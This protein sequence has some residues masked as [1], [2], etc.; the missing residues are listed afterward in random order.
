MQSIELLVREQRGV[1]RKDY[2][3][4]QGVPVHPM[5]PE[6]VARLG[7]FDETG[8]RIPANVQVEGTD[9]DGMVRWVL[10]SFAVDVPAGDERRFFLKEAEGPAPTADRLESSTSS[11]NVFVFRNRFFSLEFT[12]PGLMRLSTADGLLVDGPIGFDIRS[13]ARSAVGNLRPVEYEP[14]GFQVVECT[15]RRAKIVLK[16]RYKAWAPKQF[17]FDPVQR[18]DADV[19]F[20][21][22][23]DSPVIR[24]RWCIT[25]FM[26]FNCSYMWLDRYVLRF[27]LADGSIVTE[28]AEVPDAEKFADWVTLQTPGGK[29]SMTFPFYSWLGKG[30]GIEVTDGKLGQGG[31]N[32]PPDG[33]FGGKFPDIWRKFYHGMSRTFEGSL[34]IGGSHDQILAELNHIPIVVP[35]KHYSDCHILPENGSEISFGPWKDQIDRAAEYLLD[36]QWKG[37]LWFGEWWRERDVEHD[38][39]IEET[40]SGNSALGPL[41]H[42]FRTGDWRFWESAKMSYLYTWDIQFCKREDGWGPYM[43]TR[44]FLL[45]HQ[46]WFHP[47]Y[48]RVGGMIRCSHFFGDRRNRDKV[49]WFLRFWGDN[50]VAEDGAPMAPHG[51]GREK[52]TA[53]QKSKCGESAMSNFADSLMYAYVETGDRWFLEKAMLIGDWVV[54]GAE[55]NLDRFCENSNSTRYI[56]R[57]LLQLC[58]VTG[59]RRYIDTFVKIARWTVN[60]PTFD[61]GT[62]YVAFHFYYASQAYK[63]SGARDILEGI[64]RLAKWVLSKESPEQ[65]GTYPFPQRGQYPTTN[66]MCIYDNKAIVS[67]LPVLASA[68]DEAGIADP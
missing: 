6:D 31:I 5:T 9:Q 39:G 18:Y 64:L 54:R 29:L 32:P 65:P 66:W 35:P 53:D 58:Q 24:F 21:V 27:P 14:L 13:D 47:R 46:E 12:N 43:H 59:E 22:Y 60:A 36:W 48:Q 4:E 30:A 10:V 67:Y 28:G 49:I 1:S 52:P 20:T 38:L 11:D 62:H 55:A 17:F 51:D 57:G 16:G 25:D 15:E 44:R 34:V 7:V 33:G 37:T 40:N 3:V 50:Y 61:Y 68:L 26:K 19:E 41:Y 2:A 8:S 45:D 42:F 63:W 23:A 56:L